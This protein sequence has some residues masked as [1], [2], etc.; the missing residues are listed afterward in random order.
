[1]PGLDIGSV[2]VEP[3]LD[4]LVYFYSFISSGEGLIIENG[5]I[6]FKSKAKTPWL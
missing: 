2:I 1:M 3:D 6:V 5:E 4:A